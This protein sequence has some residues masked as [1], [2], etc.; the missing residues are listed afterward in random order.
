MSGAGH[1]TALKILEDH[2]FAAIDNLPIALVDPLIALEVETV[3]AKLQSGLMSAPVGF[4]KQLDTLARN[5]HKRLA[6]SFGWYL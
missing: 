5:L 6:V 4:P 3:G 2:G 1:S